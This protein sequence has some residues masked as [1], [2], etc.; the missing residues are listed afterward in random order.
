[1]GDPVDED[2]IWEDKAFMAYDTEGYVKLAKGDYS[3]GMPLCVCSMVCLRSDAAPQG[4]RRLTSATAGRGWGQA[5]S[6]SGRCPASGVPATVPAPSQPSSAS[7]ASAD[8]DGV[9]VIDRFQSS[10]RWVDRSHQSR[11]TAASILDK[12]ANRARADLACVRV[13]ACVTTQSAATSITVLMGAHS[14]RSGGDG[15]AQLASVDSA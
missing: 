2:A 14:R 8:A 10:R 7:T 1:M 11:A 12:R 4:E 3:E 15:V 13:H 6:Q 9:G 5:R